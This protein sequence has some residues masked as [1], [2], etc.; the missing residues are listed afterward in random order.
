MRTIRNLAWFLLAFMLTVWAGL[1]TA[2]APQ[3]MYYHAQV[4]GGAKFETIADLGPAWAAYTNGIQSSYRYTFESVRT[5]YL[6]FY[7]KRCLVSNLSS[8]STV[9]TYVSRVMWC[10]TGNAAPIT[11]LPTNQQCPDPEPDPPPQTCPYINGTKFTFHLTDGTGPKG[12]AFP[13]NPSPFPQTSDECYLTGPPEVK[14]CYAYPLDDKTD[15]F[16]CTYEGVS[17]GQ[18]V[19]R[20][21]APGRAL[22]P[23]QADEQ[24]KDVPQKDG[25]DSG[26]PKG[27]VN[28]GLNSDGIPR[29]QGTGTDPKNKPPSLPKVETEKT[30]T[31]DDGTK[32]TTKTETITNSDGS[33][34]VVKTVTVVKP[35]GTKQTNQDKTTT[36]KPAGGPGKDD[37]QKDDEKYDLCK[38][39]PNL[40]IC[41]N[42]SVAG[43]CGE[44]SCTGDAIQ[45]ATLR[46]AAAMQ[47]KQQTDEEALKASPLNAIGQAAING[48]GLDAFPNPGNGQIVNLPSLQSQG[49]LGNGSA[50]EDVSVSIQGQEV[51]VP[52]SKWS[53]YLLP[54]RFIM[55][56]IASLISYKILS[57]AILRS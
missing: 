47:C 37:S 28:V 7:A 8:C 51:L 38:Q 56:I 1:A 27:T 45:C 41:Q 24:R 36:D 42:S 21:Q 17:N 53:Q 16:A 14:N 48:T 31:A 46:A 23:E 15:Q 13:T 3:Y 10:K 26:C 18:N 29:C 40:T 57:G 49:W 20:T 25:N 9:E 22:S 33:Q 50:F 35:D 2:A 52:L 32:T 19:D 55:M 44:I 34:T 54:F 4:Q 12:A 39:N 5:G 30:E 11:A 6:S 43:K